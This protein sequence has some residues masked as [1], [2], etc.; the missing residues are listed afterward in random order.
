M[1]EFYQRAATPT[2]RDI[3][4]SALRFYQTGQYDAALA[5]FNEVCLFNSHYI[6]I[7]HP[8]NLNI[9]PCF[10]PIPV[11]PISFMIHV[12]QSSPKL[13]RTKTL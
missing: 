1:E 2:F 5:D 9:R 4:N 11:T 13:D 7:V 8:P 12:L 10:V 6:Y 3:F